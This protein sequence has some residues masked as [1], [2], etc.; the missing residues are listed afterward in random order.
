M[1]SPDSQEKQ[2]E[3]ERKEATARNLRKREQK[4]AN[5]AKSDA[6]AEKKKQE[7]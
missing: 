5:K 4:A 3:K 1:D 2:L 7:R 6:E